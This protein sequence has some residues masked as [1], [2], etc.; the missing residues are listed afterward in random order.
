MKTELENKELSKLLYYLASQKVTHY[1]D[2]EEYMGKSR[3]TVN[4]YLNDLEQWLTGK[5]VKLI[6]QRKKGIY[7]EGDISS[8]IIHRANNK[9]RV[10]TGAG[11]FVHLLQCK[12][13][14]TIDELADTFY[15]SARTMSRRIE[16][17]KTV[18]RAKVASDKN[19][20]Y[21][22]NLNKKNIKA[23]VKLLSA[24]CSATL[25]SR[26]NRIKFKMKVPT[27][28]EEY[29]SGTFVDKM[30]QVLIDFCDLLSIQF[31]QHEFEQLLFRL[32]ALVRARLDKNDTTACK[33]SLDDS[34]NLLTKLIYRNFNVNFSDSEL[35]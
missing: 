6:R 4:K 10:S 31:R 11:V 28:L 24:S 14:I 23:L 33:L 26:G 8:L 16:E 2:I 30:Q 9:K 27:F 19:G 25:L 29:I 22:D 5:N 1:A 21:I 13:P 12:T 32:L 20:V 34:V 3:M 7:L 35:E 17:V 18:L 15:V